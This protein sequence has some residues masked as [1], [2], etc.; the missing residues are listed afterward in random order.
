[1]TIMKERKSNPEATEILKQIFIDGVCKFFNCNHYTGSKAKGDVREV[2]YFVEKRKTDQNIWRIADDD[3]TEG[4]I[5]IA[6]P[7]AEEF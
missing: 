1:M 4:M 6:K 2:H 5:S 3:L 7:Y